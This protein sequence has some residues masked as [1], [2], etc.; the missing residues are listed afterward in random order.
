MKNTSISKSSFMRG[1]Q[2]LKALWLHKHRPELMPQQSAS[3]DARSDEGAVVGRLA[4]GLFPGGCEIP[5]GDR[6]SDKLLELTGKRIKAGDAPIYEAAISAAGVFVRVDILVPTKKGWEIYEVKSST[7]IKPHQYRDAAVQYYALKEACLKIS[8]VFIVHI[9]SAYV[10]QG[11][12][13]IRRLFTVAE[14]SSQAINLQGEVSGRLKKMRENL[15]GEEPDIAIG[16]QC[17]SPHECDFRGYCWRHVPENSVL[18]ITGR[19]KKERFEL[20]KEGI[21]AMTDLSGDFGLNPEQKIQVEGVKTGK[22]VMDKAALSRFLDALWYPLCFLDFETW[23]PAVPPFDNTKPYGH[24]PVQYSLHILD[25]EGGELRHYEYLADGRDDPRAQLTAQLVGQVPENSCVLAYNKSFEINVLKALECVCPDYAG[26][27]ASIRGNVQDLMDPFRNKDYYTPQMK[28]KHS[29]KY[30]LP[31]VVPDMKY[32]GRITDG[33]AA[34]SAFAKLRKTNDPAGRD[35]LRRELLDYCKQDTL[36]MVR[37][38]EKV[39][40]AAS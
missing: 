40:E 17:D 33:D 35:M 13:D 10:R 19:G 24:I 31:A 7:K 34:M 32:E 30:V 15:Q 22:S 25:G 2:C 12:L 18:D 27:V 37:I 28:G 14:V 9:N 38:L 1:L 26:A 29:I 11:A 4:R 39:R 23:A 20:Y 21:A 8:G 5:M 36:A 3:L 16:L 6:D